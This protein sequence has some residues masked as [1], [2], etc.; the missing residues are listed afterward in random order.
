MARTR[1][2]SPDVGTV[3]TARSTALAATRQVGGGQ[4]R[5]AR[6]RIDVGVGT[7]A[8]SVGMGLDD[9]CVGRIVRRQPVGMR[10]REGPVSQEFELFGVWCAP[11]VGRPHVAVRLVHR[12]R[13]AEGRPPG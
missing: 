11:T 3:S 12:T 4:D 1:D 6:A 8:E 5:V 2:R 10:F 9:L 7:C 13:A